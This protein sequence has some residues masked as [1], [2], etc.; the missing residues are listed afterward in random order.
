M[1]TI[2]CANKNL[3]ITYFYDFSPLINANRNKKITN[4]L[5]VS[6]FFIL[7][8]DFIILIYLQNLRLLLLNEHK[9]LL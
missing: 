1:Y 5:S 8:K 4:A 2:L 9:L 6:D 7:R 3:I